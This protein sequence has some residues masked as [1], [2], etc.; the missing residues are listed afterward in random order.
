MGSSAAVAMAALL[1]RLGG[2]LAEPPLA[3][4]LTA[5]A[6]FDQLLLDFLWF[7]LA[8]VWAVQLPGRLRLVGYALLGAFGIA[9]TVQLVAVAVS[10]QMLSLLAVDNLR[11]VHLVF[12]PH[13]VAPVAAVL[14]TLAGIAWALDRLPPSGVGGRVACSLGLLAAVGALRE[15][16]A[17]LPEPAA[18]GRR[19]FY[20]DKDNFFE[21]GSPIAVLA[22][23]L[24]G[25]RADKMRPL[26][27]A[28]L[29]RAARFGVRLTTDAE[30][31]FVRDTLASRPVSFPTR[32]D[33]AT[34]PNLVVFFAEGLSART[35]ESYGGAFPK[36]T[37]SLASLAD[38]GMAV[39]RYYNHTY[40]TYRGLQGQLCS[41]F[42]RHGG[43]Q[44]WRGE[45]GRLKNPNYYC[46]PHL[47]RD[48]GYETVFADADLRDDSYL[49]EMM[50]ELGFDRIDSGEALAAR[51]LGGE[52]PLGARSLSDYQTMQAVIGLVR[53]LE[54][55]GPDAKPF[56][57]AVYTLQTHAFQQL[58]RDGVD[59]EGAENHALDTIHNLDA[60]FGD[61]MDALDGS[62]LSE[63][64]V[65]VFTTDHAHFPEPDYVELVGD[66]PD[67]VPV[68]V[69]RI[70]LIVVHPG[71][72][73]PARFDARRATSIDLAPTLAHLLG[74]EARRTPFLGRSLF[75][76]D[77]RGSDAV[78][79]AAAGWDVH[80]IDAQGIHTR[81]HQSVRGR[82]KEQLDFL[83]DLLRTLYA[84]EG[85]D[86]IWPRVGS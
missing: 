52:D 30:Y 5:L 33:A 45:P 66:D 8:L 39:D 1:A 9:Y 63:E 35:L 14:L 15:M 29:E 25:Q 62:T 37:P 83:H 7:A 59:Y 54:A 11:H 60:A 82:T 69:D 72:S 20:A 47:L 77:R 79:V 27:R 48:E 3:A 58:S 41:I 43:V 16:D 18:S 42:P 50:S 81:G 57:L 67:Y 51:Y 22:R 68:F 56:F 84:I 4:P 21:D 6:V 78:G 31:P 17:W 26:T 70:P 23:V 74:F 80:L 64:T 28:D 32:E 73:L 85:R 44:D 76:R 86:R 46:L 36:L 75:D 61:F 49:D 2:Y 10:G 38:R 65:V 24:R 34:R 13:F 55:R 19:A 71:L 12:Q 40:A 53:E